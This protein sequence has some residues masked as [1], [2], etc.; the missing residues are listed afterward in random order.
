MNGFSAMA[1]ELT[2]DALNRGVKHCQQHWTNYGNP[3]TDN[4]WYY[5]ALLD[6]QEKRNKCQSP[7]KQKRAGR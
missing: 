2:D 3:A 5:R 6:E 1:A 7:R 4:Y